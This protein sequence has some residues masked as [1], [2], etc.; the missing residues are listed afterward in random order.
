M[1]IDI[2]FILNRKI[3]SVEKKDYSWFFNL[4]EGIT[5]G[6]ESAWRLIAANKT[7]LT[8]DDDGQK[9]GLPQPIDAEKEVS[10]LLNSDPI[11]KASFDKNT[12]DLFLFFSDDKILQFLQLSSGYESWRISYPGKEIICLGGGKIDTF[13]I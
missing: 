10:S 9:F 13:D 6:T 2:S 4:G 12:G 8:S 7:R 1:I 3:L 5:I 11:T